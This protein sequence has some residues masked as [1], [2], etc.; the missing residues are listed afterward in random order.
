MG[1]PTRIISQPCSCLSICNEHLRDSIVIVFEKVELKTNLPRY[2]H[3]VCCFIFRLFLTS[4]QVGSQK[5]TYRIE[6]PLSLCV[7]RKGAFKSFLP[8]YALR[9]GLKWGRNGLVTEEGAVPNGVNLWVCPTQSPRKTGR[10]NNN[11]W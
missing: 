4:Y 10:H 5:P 9:G 2:D 1:F 6:P 8:V 7:C 3:Q 11:R